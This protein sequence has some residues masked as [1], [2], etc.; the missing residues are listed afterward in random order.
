MHNFLSKINLSK[1]FRADYIFE[2]S[3]VATGLYL[4]FLIVFGIF[5]VLSLIFFILLRR[6]NKIYHKLYKRASIF[7]LVIGLIGLLLIFFRFEQIPY[8]SSRLM[9]LGLAIVFLLWGG[10]IGFYI[11][12]TLP[13]EKKELFKKQKFIKYLPRHKG[14]LPLKAVK[15]NTKW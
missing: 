3:P 5:I 9:F 11:I 7:F 4:Y 1:L 10:W 8:L 14:G 13:K 6:K 12:F 2:A 15:G